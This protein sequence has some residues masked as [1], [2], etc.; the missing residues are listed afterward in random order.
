MMFFV[1]CFF[2]EVGG[3]GELEGENELFGFMTDDFAWHAL[4]RYNF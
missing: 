4:R 1:F 3:G 2:E